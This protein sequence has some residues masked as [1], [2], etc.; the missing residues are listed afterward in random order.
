MIYPE[1]LI[2]FG[3]RSTED[4]EEEIIRELGIT[5]Y[6][7]HEIH[8]RSLESCLAESIS[9][10]SDV[11]Y[12]YISFDV[13]A[14]DCNYVSDGT[15][16]PVSDGFKIY[17]IIE[18]LEKFIDTRKVVAFEVCEINPLLDTGGNEMAEVTFDVILNTIDR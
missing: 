5:C 9:K 1:D 6:W 2:Y 8:H 12:F 16:Y 13:D 15:G 11:A 3:P 10:M 4:E 18:I 17:E 14:F 7:M